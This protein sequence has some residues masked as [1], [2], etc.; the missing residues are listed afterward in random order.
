[1]EETRISFFLVDISAFESSS[2]VILP[3]KAPLAFG[4]APDF[5]LPLLFFL[6][7]VASS[8]IYS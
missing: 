3:F 6:A 5:G 1:M 2:F 4:G 7:K 8:S